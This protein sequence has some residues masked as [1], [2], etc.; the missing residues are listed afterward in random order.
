MNKYKHIFFDL[1]RTLWDFD[2]NSKETLQDIYKKYNLHARGVHSFEI[3]HSTYKTINKSLWA[4]YRLGTITKDFLSVQR[5]HK[6]LQ[7]FIIEDLE[8]A[9]KISSD[10]I[11]ISPTK[12]RLFPYTHELLSYLNS[13]YTM[14]IITNGFNE[15]QFKKVKNAG[16]EKY[17][18]TIIT[19]EDAGAKKPDKKSF[20]YALE[21]TGAEIENS[22]MI[23]DDLKTDIIGAKNTGI[24]QIFVNYK[25]TNKDITPTYEVFSLKDIENI[26]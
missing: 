17:F 16:L 5:Y 24:D 23:G 13:K 6:T 11:N 14:H 22:I 7:Y 18:T 8:L 10:Y 21:N 20:Y 12:T 1:D 2:E 19:S 15:V 26:L 25:K 3:F 4:D 9:T